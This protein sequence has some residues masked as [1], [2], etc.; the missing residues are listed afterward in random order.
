[1]RAP[2]TT[3]FDVNKKAKMKGPGQMNWGSFS[4]LLVPVQTNLMEIIRDYHF[5]GDK[6]VSEIKDR[7]TGSLTC[8]VVCTIIVH[9]THSRPSRR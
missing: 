9:C 6:I 8:T 5:E 7:A 1:M 2:L 4:P 3:Y